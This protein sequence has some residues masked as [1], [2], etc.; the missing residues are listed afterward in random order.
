MPQYSY[1]SRRPTNHTPRPN[2]YEEHS[3]PYT[4]TTLVARKSA[5]GRKMKMHTRSITP[6]AFA[7]YSIMCS[8]TQVAPNKNRIGSAV[9]AR[10]MASPKRAPPSA[11]VFSRIELRLVFSLAGPTSIVAGA[12][13][14]SSLVALARATPVS[15]NG[16]GRSIARRSWGRSPTFIQS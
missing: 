2:T 5:S 8:A 14:L 10:K 12:A 11:F 7:T 4:L 15:G 3:N 13:A 9:I 16:G 6:A 1:A